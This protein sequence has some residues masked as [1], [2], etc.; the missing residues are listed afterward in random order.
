MEEHALRHI[1]RAAELLSFGAP[2]MR[3]KRKRTRRNGDPECVEGE[4]TKLSR[5]KMKGLKFKHIEVRKSNNIP[6]AQC[7]VFATRFILKDTVIGAYTGKVLMSRYSN[8]MMPWQ[9][10]RRLDNSERWS[11]VMENVDTKEFIDGWKGHYESNILSYVNSAKTPS[12]MLL[13]NCSFYS[14]DQ[15]N[16]PS[17]VKHGIWLVADRSIP[18]NTELI[19]DY[20]RN[21]WTHEERKGDVMDSRELTQQPE[22]VQ[23]YDGRNATER[24]RRIDYLRLNQTSKRRQSSHGPAGSLKVGQRVEGRFL[25]ASRDPRYYKQWYPARV[26][27]VNDDGTFDLRYA[28]TDDRVVEQD[29]PREFVRTEAEMEFE[30]VSRNVGDIVLA[31]YDAKRNGPWGT[32]MY[33]ARITRVNTDGSYNLRYLDG[34]KEYDV[35]ARFMKAHHYMA[36]Y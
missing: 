9:E 5:Q 34:V 6:A 4:V 14:T 20:G 30:P 25:A 28:D 21:Y 10:V 3:H 12:Q 29:V 24:K 2:K 15:L 1:S 13:V 26:I 32:N 19:T 11:Y 23:Y 16:N 31:R 17:F 35:P 33:I 36:T 7:G 22:L 18:K 8:Q 27:N